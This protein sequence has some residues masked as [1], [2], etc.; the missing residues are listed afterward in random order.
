MSYNVRNWLTMDRYVDQKNLKGAPKPERER[1]AVID[2]IV[3]H[4]PDVIGLSEIGTP[5]D[6]AEI[7]YRLR[8]NGLDLP[9]SHYTGGSDFVRHLGL[10]SKFPIVSTAKPIKSHLKWEG[11]TISLNRGILDATVNI[12]GRS[13]RFVGVHLKSKREV[14]GLDQESIR[15]GEAHLLRSHVDAIFRNEPNIRMLV[16][17]DFNDTRSSIAVKTIVGNHSDPS[18]LTAIPFTDRSGET[19][20]HFWDLHEIY[21]R[22]DFVTISRRLKDEVDFRSSKIIDDPNWNE[23]SDHRPVL[24]IFR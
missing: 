4:S 17:G 1:K 8:E 15:R 16:Y 2:I 12:G 22:I 18:Y 21:S 9:H 19:W 23:A 7:Q 5:E 11:R 14:E 13:Y 24:A 10:L 20:T 6:L 3:R